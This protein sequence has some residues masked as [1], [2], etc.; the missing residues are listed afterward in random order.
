MKKKREK[1][2]G[3]KE[4]KRREIKEKEETRYNRTWEPGDISEVLNFM[5]CIQLV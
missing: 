3:R 2:G 5:L 4:R 1:V